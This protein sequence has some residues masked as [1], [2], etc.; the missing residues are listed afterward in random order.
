[1][2][3]HVMNEYAM[4]LCNEGIRYIAMQSYSIFITDLNTK[5]EPVTTFRGRWGVLL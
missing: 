1:L 3:T 5:I 4:S 2:F